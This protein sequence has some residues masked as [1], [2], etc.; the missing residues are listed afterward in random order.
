[1]SDKKGIPI[2]EVWKKYE[3]I[4]MH[5]NDLLIK[6]GTQAIGG[7]AAITTLTAVISSKNT[8][9]LWDTMAV[10][11]FF[12]A[13]FWVAVWLLDFKYYNRLL[14]GAVH[15]LKQVEKLSE[16]EE[17]V[18]QLELSHIVEKSVTGHLEQ[19]CKKK[20][21]C[22]LSKVKSYFTLDNWHG[23]PA[24]GRNYFYGIIF[25]GLVVGFIYCLYKS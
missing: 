20:K 25:I 15:A 6:L 16:T 14:L 13:I 17:F 18:T 12:L 21:F 7:V 5:F 22:I 23:H 2:F 8:V 19:T 11:F 24:F 3:E 10:V 9:F 1:M 4:A